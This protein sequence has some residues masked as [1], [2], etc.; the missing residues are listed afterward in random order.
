MNK[1]VHKHIKSQN[2]QDAIE[3]G[4]YDGRFKTKSIPL[5]KHKENKYKKRY[6]LFDED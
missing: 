1:K 4:F 6:D 5:K 3:E 2:R